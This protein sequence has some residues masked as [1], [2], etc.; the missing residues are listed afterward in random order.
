MG[1]GNPYARACMLILG[2]CFLV[3][4]AHAAVIGEKQADRM[5]SAISAPNPT[6][7]GLAAQ[8][9]G[10]GTGSS[11]TVNARDLRCLA[12]GIYFE[13][14]GEPTRGKL[15]VGR[16]ILNRVAS[17]NYPNSV[18]RVVYQN[19]HLRDRC[20]FS[21]ACDGKPDIVAEREVWEE[22][23]R[24][25]AWLLSHDATDRHESELWTST[26]F[27]AD[28]VSPRWAKHLTLTERVGRH[29]FYR[30]WRVTPIEVSPSQSAPG[31]TAQAQSSGPRPQPGLPAG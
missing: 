22:I 1:L 29:L 11:S 13:A 7:V 5:W 30:D 20:Q 9:S 23:L 12:R 25:A 15:A 6:A 21:F 24:Y 18:C 4:P 3:Q 19:D 8:L 2:F 26:H 10:E 28:Y 17:K 31:V 16:V 27:H 14:R